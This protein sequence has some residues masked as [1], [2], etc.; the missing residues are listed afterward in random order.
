MPSSRAPVCNVNQTRKPVKIVGPPLPPIPKA[1]DLPSAIQAINAITQTINVIVNNITPS[2]PGGQTG[3]G[4]FTEQNAN[5]TEVR[6]QRVTTTQRIFNPQD[7][8]QYVDV[9]QITGLSFIDPDT[10]Q[11]IVWKQ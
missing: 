6:A 1:T 3:G 10:K 11:T 4:G 9:Q 7:N 2:N 5:F 8:T